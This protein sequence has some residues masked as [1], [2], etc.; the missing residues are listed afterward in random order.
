VAAFLH[1]QRTGLRRLDRLRELFAR[2]GKLTRA[3]AAAILGVTPKTATGDLRALCAEGL[4]E[5]VMPSASRRT[6]YFRLKR[7]E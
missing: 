3:E 2:H 4:V 5:K 7:E 1:R 6:H